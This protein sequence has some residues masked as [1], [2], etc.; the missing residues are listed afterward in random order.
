MDFK[1]KNAQKNISSVFVK[2]NN[3][4]K[5]IIAVI[6]AELAGVFGSVFT[7]PNIESWYAGLTKPALNPPAWVFDPVWTTLYFLMGVALFLV[8]KRNF[9]IS[10]SLLANDKKPWNPWSRRL[11]RGNLQTFNVIAIFTVQYIL[12]IVWS[13]IFFG[14]HLPNVAFFVILALWFSILFTIMN[15]YRVSKPAAWLLV[16]YILWVSFAAYLNLAI[17]L[18][19]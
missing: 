2:I 3:V 9:K 15:F 18:I 11:W 19:N 10:H 16:P 14:M 17:W 4:F 8:W 1:N 7:V 6:I 5:L 12:N 13:W